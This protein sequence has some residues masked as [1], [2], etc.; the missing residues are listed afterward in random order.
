VILN[1]TG[2]DWT[3]YDNELQEVLGTPSPGADGLS[4]AQG[5]SG[6]RPF[7][8]SV[9]PNVDEVVDVR[10]YVNFS[11]ATVADGETVWIQYAITDNSP[12]ETVY[13]RQRP[14][15]RPGVPEGGAAVAFALTVLGMLSYARRSKE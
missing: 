6:N 14:N 10:D 4:F 12:I 5:S 2:A 13:L 15:Y 11:G 1:D 3:Y 7:S 8:S 9:W